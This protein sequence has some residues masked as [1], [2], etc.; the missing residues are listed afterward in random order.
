MV[1]MKAG[2]GILAGM[3]ALGTLFIVGAGRSRSDATPPA[4]PSTRKMPATAGPVVASVL[5]EKTPL[6]ALDEKV[7]LLEERTKELQARRDR[8]A[9]DNKEKDLQAQVFIAR[10]SAKGTT[11][12]WMSDYKL[13][14][15]QRGPMH[16][17]FEKWLCEDAAGEESRDLDARTFQARESELRSLLTPEQLQARHEAVKGGI[18]DLWKSLGICVSRLQEGLHPGFLMLGP[19]WTPE[20]RALADRQLLSPL[21]L[22]QR[23]ALDVSTPSTA[24][25]PN[26]LGECPAIPDSVLLADAHDLGILGLWRKAEPR[27]RS[28][29]T[30]DQLEKY[31]QLLPSNSNLSPHYRHGY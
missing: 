16:R 28:L 14:D 31:A 25:D 4:L 29:L 17:L 26:L 6:E 7:R 18:E 15:A 9:A 10:E 19:P 22:P 3:A 23:E 27:V 24:P 2:W 20:S 1:N 5:P 30:A 13:T 12:R 8:A 11:G 21:G